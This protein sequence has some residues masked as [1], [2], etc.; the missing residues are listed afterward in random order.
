MRVIQVVP[1]IAEEASGPSYSV[2]ALAA[3]LQ[4]HCESVQLHV[5]APAKSQGGLL[6]VRTYPTWNLARTL[7]ISPAMSRAL[8]SN[9]R[10]TDVM[11]N[12]SLWMMPN[13]YPA[14]AIKHTRCAL[15]TSPRG[16]LSPA[17]LRR[18]AWRKRVM[19]WLCQG[20]AVRASHCFHATS[21]QEM[22]DI[23]NAGL[24][25]PIALIPNGIDIAPL[26]DDSGATTGNRRVLYLSRIHPIKG[27]ET[28]LKAWSKIEIQ[29]PDWELQIVGPGE[30]SYVRSLQSLAE[31]LNLRRVVF[32]G[33]RYGKTK[34]EA[35][36]SAELFVLP[37][38]S[39]N[40][41]MAVA[42]ALAHGVPAIVTQGAPWSGLNTHDC[43]WWIP[44][45]D[46][47]LAECML[48]A[49]NLSRAEL[50]TKGRHGR[51]WML[52]EFSWAKVGKQM[53][54]SYC[55]LRGGGSL[56]GFMHR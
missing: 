1:G 18:S 56:P 13:I 4:P 25:G 46:A 53:H 7:G 29:I 27:I 24:R 14:Q 43:G 35:Y 42:E 6:D 49:A 44:H 31:S 34:R 9:A 10:S 50:R 20:K 2:P 28:L 3:A 8:T 33:P 26:A 48:A 39:E 23:R 16:T 54:E 22:M 5:L 32:E 38:H 11:H 47:V 30:P 15:V 37:S 51:D 17:A 40:F 21:E 12:H 55:W 41:G 19:W 45:D 36:H 52:Q